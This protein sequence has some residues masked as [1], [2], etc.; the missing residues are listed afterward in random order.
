MPPKAEIKTYYYRRFV[1]VQ[2]YKPDR[3]R[4][5]ENAY[6]EGTTYVYCPVRVKHSGYENE[7][8]RKACVLFTRKEVNQIMEFFSQPKSI[9]P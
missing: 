3:E 8:I 7:D 2:S 5:L 4:I 1:R 6:R 9:V